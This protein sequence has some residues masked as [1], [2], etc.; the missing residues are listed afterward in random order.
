VH[1]ELAVVKVAKYGVSP[2]GDTVEIAE[3][4]SGGMSV[5]VVDGQG[6]GE[7]A[8]TISASVATK[9]AGLIAEGVRDGAAARA[10]HD[11]LYS[12]RRAKVQASLAILSADL[13]E[14][15][16]LA[17]R[18]TACPALYL[19]EGADEIADEE[20]LVIGVHRMIRPSIAQY[21]LQPGSALVT[22]TDGVHQA[23]R[24]KGRM[25]RPEQAAAV[26]RD[27]WGQGADGMAR[28]LLAAA[29]EAD[30]GR[31]AD[32]MTVAVLRIEPDEGGERI[33]SITARY[34]LGSDPPPSMG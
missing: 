33:R 24:G 20:A 4:P 13:A 28:A 5:V 9:A 10:V 30:G 32:D 7:A 3:R 1:L 14:R 8:R 19:G 2:A 11:Y 18:N 15:K 12:H 27:A 16:L 31:P 26:L 23:G 17:S 6:S 29:L 25:L 21:P 34:P 22:Y